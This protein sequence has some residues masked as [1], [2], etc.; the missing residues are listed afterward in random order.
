MAITKRIQTELQRPTYFSD[1]DLDFTRNPATGDIVL[2]KNDLAIRRSVRNLIMLNFGEKPFHVEIG[3][4]VRAELFNLISPD[5]AGR[6]R[7]Q[8][9][10]C[11]QNFE[12]RVDLKEVYVDPNYSNDGY[13]IRIEFF[14]KNVETQVQNIT[15]FLER[16]R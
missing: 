7:T 14:L 2:L 10:Q 12:P 6:L 16:I 13:D 4:S 3:S 9:A 15:L 11:I 8:I 5:S 1:L